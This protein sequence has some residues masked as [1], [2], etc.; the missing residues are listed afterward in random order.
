MRNAR[1]FVQKSMVLS[2]ITMVLSCCAPY[3]SNRATK[4]ARENGIRFYRIPQEPEKRWLWLIAINRKDYNSRPH[5][6]ICSTNFV[7][8]KSVLVCMSRDYSEYIA[9]MVQTYAAH[10]VNCTWNVSNLQ[11]RKV[12]ILSPQ[13]MYPQFLEQRWV[14]PRQD[15]SRG[16]MKLL[17]TSHR[18][19]L[20]KKSFRDQ[21]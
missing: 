5:T 3:C 16:D 6:Y 12:M 20:F 8:G 9:F 21:N 2:N 14:H 10:V 15:K 13:R 4:E 1:I 7:G 18:L 11:E 17:S 19:Q